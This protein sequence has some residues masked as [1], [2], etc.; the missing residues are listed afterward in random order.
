MRTAGVLVAGE[1]LERILAVLSAGGEGQLLAPR[2]GETA[3]A[4]LGVNGTATMLMSRDV[5]Y[6]SLCT[7]D[8]VSE[9][10]EKL[11]YS[12][13]VRPRAS[14]FSHGRPLTGVAEDVIEKR[15]GFE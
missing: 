14:A 12:L 13:G 7:T 11:H 1:R 2:L 8:E 15:L 4:V 3:T 6:G 9:L 10:I 5:P